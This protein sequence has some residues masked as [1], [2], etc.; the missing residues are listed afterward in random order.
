MLKYV[1]YDTQTGIIYSWS[2]VEPSAESLVEDEAVIETPLTFV[3]G[4]YFKVD[5]KSKTVY[6][7]VYAAPAEAD[8]TLVRQMRTALLTQTDYVMTADYPI[9]P[10]LL[11]RVKAYRT[12][13]RNIT[14]TFKTPEEVVWPENPLRTEEMVAKQANS[15][16]MP[17]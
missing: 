10:E 7:I 11:D 16:I 8:W 9:E 4:K 15:V 17:G 2:D 13:L 14:T 3:P 12:A 6:E 1:I 5:L